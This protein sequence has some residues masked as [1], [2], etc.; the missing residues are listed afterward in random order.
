MSIN[1]HS[2]Y[3]RKLESK[4]KIEKI[5]RELGWL[6]KLIGQ[7]PIIDKAFQPDKD[8][9]GSQWAAVVQT[10]K[11]QM[12]ALKTKDIPS[13]QHGDT[14]NEHADEVVISDMSYIDKHFQAKQ[15]ASQKLRVLEKKSFFAP[16]RLYF[17]FWPEKEIIFSV[18]G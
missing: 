2:S 9:S 16:K 7:S 13:S 12:L 5:V 17:F 4:N 18:D 15:E 10:A 3:F 14:N 6:D 8:Q 11:K 1:P